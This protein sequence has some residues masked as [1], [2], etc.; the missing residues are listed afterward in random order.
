VCGLQHEIY[1][2]ASLD[3]QP[4]NR[5]TGVQKIRNC[6]LWQLNNNAAQSWQQ[7][8]YALQQGCPDRV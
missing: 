3:R 2:L 5:T 7:A 8:I 6:Q 4:D 1:G